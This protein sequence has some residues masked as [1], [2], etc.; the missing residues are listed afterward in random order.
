MTRHIV[1]LAQ[2]VPPAAG[3]QNDPQMHYWVPILAGA[4][5]LASPLIRKFVRFIR[6]QIRFWR[7]DRRL[8]DGLSFNPHVDQYVD[9]PRCGNRHRAWG[10]NPDW[11]TGRFK[12][13][14]CGALFDLSK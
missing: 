11:E 12:C 10:L 9:C 3:Q 2:Q 14:E 13:S 4:L 6:S 7:N 8:H 1:A 5:L